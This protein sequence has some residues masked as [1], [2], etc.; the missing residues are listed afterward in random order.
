ME[1]SLELAFDT[2]EA[3]FV[4]GVEV[5]LLWERLTANADPIEVIARATNTEML[6]RMAENLNRPFGGEVLDDCWLRVSFGAPTRLPL[7]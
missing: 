6:M 2:D 3:E 4:R 7:D 5:G 1:M